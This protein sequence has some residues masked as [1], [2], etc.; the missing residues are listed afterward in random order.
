MQAIEFRAE[1][2]RRY[3]MSQDHHGVFWMYVYSRTGLLLDLCSLGM[4]R[5]RAEGEFLGL[6]YVAENCRSYAYS[7]PSGI[8]ADFQSV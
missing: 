6:A 4:V 7:A 2:G 1:S 8:R 5:D 3:R